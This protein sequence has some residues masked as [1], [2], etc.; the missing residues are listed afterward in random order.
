MANKKQHLGLLGNLK[1]KMYEKDYIHII[2][3]SN[4]KVLEN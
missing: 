4:A 1:Y 3:Q 2:S